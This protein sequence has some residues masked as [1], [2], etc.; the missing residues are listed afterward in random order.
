MLESKYSLYAKYSKGTPMYINNDIG[1]NT[2][3][4]EYISELKQWVKRD[5]W[6]K[7]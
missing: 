4:L 1:T 2:S 7:S 5:K 3:N 6:R